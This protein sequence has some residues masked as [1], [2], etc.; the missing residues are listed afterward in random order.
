LTTTS[1]KQ[2]KTTQLLLQDTCQGT[3]PY[4]MAPHTASA[5]AVQSVNSAGLLASEQMLTAVWCCYYRLSLLVGVGVPHH[6]QPR[7]LLGQQG[8]VAV[9]VHRCQPVPRPLLL[10]LQVAEVG[11]HH[12]SAPPLLLLLALL[13]QVGGPPPLLVL[14]LVEV[15]VAHHSHLGPCHLLLLLQ[16]GVVGVAHHQQP[17][18]PPLLVVLLQQG[19]G[20][21]GHPLHLP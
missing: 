9:V 10:L 6:H 21:G 19:V 7:V 14:L 16:V 20:V 3:T 18:A 17:V 5:A 13:L 15:V 8:V 1:L 2:H 4:T 12:P 11:R